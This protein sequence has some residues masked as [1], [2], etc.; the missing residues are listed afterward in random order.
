[1]I[2][3][4]TLYADIVLPQTLRKV[5]TYIMKTKTILVL[6]LDSLLQEQ[7]GTA[8][9]AAYTAAYRKMLQ[10]IQVSQQNHAITIQAEV[11]SI[12]AEVFSTEES[13]SFCTV[14]SSLAGRIRDEQENFDG[15]LVVVRLS[16]LVLTAA[17]LNQMIPEGAKP[18]VLTSS[19]RGIHAPVTDARA[20]LSDA[21]LYVCADET[22]GV[23]L[24]FDGKAVA[25]EHARLADPESFHAIE[26]V[27]HP[28]PAT[29]KDGVITRFLPERPAGTPAQFITNLQ[30]S[31]LSLNWLPGMRET[32]LAGMLSHYSCV[33]LRIQEWSIYAKTSGMEQ[34]H[35]AIQHLAALCPHTRFI[36]FLTESVSRLSSLDRTS[37]PGR[38]SFGNSS[39]SG[40]DPL[41]PESDG[42]WLPLNRETILEENAQIMVAQDMTEESVLA[43]AYLSSAGPTA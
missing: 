18:V 29:I 41:S 40:N 23:T 31:V 19:L 37:S 1:M 12:Q 22:R 27:G 43:L 10:D 7:K 34:L 15:F 2:R 33:I 13:D 20:N 32:D 14:I 28:Y 38:T 35:A 16:D 3:L 11:L 4:V 39:S 36:L 17:F 26:S 9:E 24:V 25:P 21:I 8:S 30:T 42:S 5:R 6:I